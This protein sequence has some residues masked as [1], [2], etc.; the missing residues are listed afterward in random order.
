MVKSN[1][2]NRLFNTIIFILVLIFII[3]IFLINRS[4]NKSKQTET[5]FN[6]NITQNQTDDYVTKLEKLQTKLQETNE[7]LVL[8]GTT[9][10]NCTYDNSNVLNTKDDNLSFLHRKFNEL[11]IKTIQVETEYKFGFTYNLEDIQIDQDGDRIKIVLSDHRLHLKYIEENK[12]KTILM[13]KVNL[14]AS[15]F[16]PQEINTIMARTKV[17]ALNTIQNNTEIIDK[18]MISTKKNI[19]IL[20]EELGV[21]VEVEISKQGLLE[22]EDVNINQIVYN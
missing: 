10:I 17:G 15:K 5:L 20:V 22:N 8:E 21:G 4:Y 9:L 3:M 6:Q 18:A 13:D 11:K 19:E 1:N 12:D 2:K 7:L 14:L 16:I